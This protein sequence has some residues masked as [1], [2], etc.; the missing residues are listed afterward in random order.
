MT[1]EIAF[2]YLSM[3]LQNRSVGATNMN[4]ESSRSHMVVIMNLST[5]NIYTGEAKSAKLI[6]VDLA[7][8][9]KISKTGAEG[10]IL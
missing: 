3:G 9:E 10:K 4:A 1:E 8:S 5:H 7:G 6:L 2:E